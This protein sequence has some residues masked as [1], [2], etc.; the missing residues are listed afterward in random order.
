MRTEKKSLAQEYLRR[1][2]AS[3][4]I[5]V[6][7]YT[8][9]KVGH[10]G[11]LR[12]RLGKIGAEMHVVKNSVFRLAAD[13]SGLPDLSGLL[14]GQ[15]AVVTGQRDISAAAKVLKTF[16]AEFERPKMQFGCLGN[17][18]LDKA[19]LL[20]LADLPSLDVLRGQLLGTMQAWQGRL[21]RLLQTPAGHLARV[22]QRR[23]E[24][25]AQT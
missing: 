11:E 10:F 21:V 2:N 4:F 23:A 20:T 3:P 22:L 6:V 12:A 16:Q 13:E 9:M 1:L 7:E 19:A 15:R 14:T 18:P 17:Q 8:G 5:I 24:E 25:A